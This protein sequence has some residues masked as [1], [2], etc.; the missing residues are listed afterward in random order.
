LHYTTSLQ[1]ADVI[2]GMT[3]DAMIALNGFGNS[4]DVL[5]GTVGM[6]FLMFDASSLRVGGVFPIGG[7]DRRLFDAEVQVQFNRRF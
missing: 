4:L 1:D 5:N 2:V 3:D 7:D 6:Q